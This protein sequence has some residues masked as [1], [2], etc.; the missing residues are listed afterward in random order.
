MG[1]SSSLTE[2]QLLSY[3]ARLNYGFA[4]KYL[5]TVSA[6]SD[7]ASQLAEGHKYS[8]FP[9]A[10]LAWRISQE[11]FLKGANWVN[12][13]KVRIGAGVTGNSAIDPYATQ[14]AITPVFYP[15]GSTLVPGSAPSSVLANQALGWEKT[16][17]YNVGVDY[18]ILNRRVSGSID[19]Y[20]SKTTDL[21]M[22]RSIP[23]VTGYTTTYAN[24]GETANKGI[25]LSINSVNIKA[26]PISLNLK[27]PLFHAARRYGL[28]KAIYYLLNL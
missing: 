4:D 9:S 18:S 21:L 28:D 26:G 22:Q 15:S 5:L 11:D 2:K 1:Y 3:M 24:I 23:T 14:G 27:L 8:L 16:I 12:D 19:V 6:R 17:Q 25:D 20:T 13:L 10:A 7:G